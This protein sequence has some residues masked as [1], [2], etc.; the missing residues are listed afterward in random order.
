M[1]AD[2]TRTGQ[3]YDPRTVQIKLRSRAQDLERKHLD[4]AV[5]RLESQGEVTGAQR[6]ILQRMAARIVDGILRPPESALSHPEETD[7]E[8]A[9]TIA[10]LFDLPE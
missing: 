7:R 9:H 1:S 5:T 2:R 4:Q 3:E 6:R 8:R 10:R